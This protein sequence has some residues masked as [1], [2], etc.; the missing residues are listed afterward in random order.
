MLKLFLLFVGIIVFIIGIYSG[1]WWLIK[2][3]RSV[4]LEWILWAF[5]GVVTIICIAYIIYLNL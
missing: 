1:S 5:I 4:N 3:L 2:Y